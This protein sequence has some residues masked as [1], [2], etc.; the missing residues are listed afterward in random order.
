MR[1]I[2]RSV[3]PRYGFQSETLFCDLPVPAQPLQLFSASLFLLP[4][5]AKP[6]PYPQP[7][8]EP[9]RK[10][11]GL[12]S[13]SVRDETRRRGFGPVLTHEGGFRLVQTGVSTPEQRRCGFSDRL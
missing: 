3:S 4:S 8:L 10:A 7:A 6:V 12:K 11:P 5:R 9:V 13:G 2:T 1:P